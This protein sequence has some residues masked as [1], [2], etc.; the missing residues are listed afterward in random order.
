MTVDGF[1]IAIVSL[2]TPFASPARAIIPAMERIDSH[3]HLD[4]PAFDDDRDAVVRRAREAGV[5][6]MV[7][8]SVGP[9]NWQRVAA[10]CQR[11]PGCR[12]AFGLH[13]WFTHPADALE[14]LDAWLAEHPAVAIGECGLDFHVREPA[15]GTQWP[16]FE[17]QLA[18]A[19]RHDLPLILHAVKAF[20]EVG[21]AVRRRGGL[22]GVVHGF[23]GSLEQGRALVDSGL[24]LGIGT[25]ATNFSRNKLRRALQA[26]P[27]EAM[28]LETDAPNQ[29]PAGLRGQRNEP[30]CIVEVAAA[31]AEIKGLDADT[32]TAASNR[33]ARELFFA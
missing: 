33:N 14:R 25:A 19:A 7:I 22:R 18:L 12:P 6:A 29:P 3:C 27:L 10:T 13:P 5:T 4:A 26:L 2:L 8:P 16:W 21:A 17:G 20:D 30:A 28:M 9:G 1:M 15:P 31:L 32:V 23:T 11:W 24:Y